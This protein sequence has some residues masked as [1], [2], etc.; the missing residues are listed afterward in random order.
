MRFALVVAAFALALGQPDSQLFAGT[1]A[2]DQHDRP[3]VRL[4]LRVESG[5]LAGWI[6]LADIHVDARGDVETV[7]SDLPEATTLLDITTQARTLTFSRR[8]G[9]EIDRFEMAV[10]DDRTAELRFLFTDALRRELADDGIPMP[11]PI[12]LTRVAQ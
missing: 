2:A 4:A 7:M 6:R 5:A 1:W 12:R 8:D 10:I 11:R 3:F 9:N